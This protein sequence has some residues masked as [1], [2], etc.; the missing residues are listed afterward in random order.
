[1]PHSVALRSYNH[2]MIKK[3]L[4]FFVF[5]AKKPDLI[6]KSDC[7]KELTN[8]V[9]DLQWH[10]VTSLENRWPHN[11]VHERWVQMLKQSIRSMMGQSGFP[12]VAWHLVVSVHSLGC[13]EKSTHASA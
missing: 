6:V 7:T 5:Y 3:N 1:M 9:E 13:H 10:A 12:M 8:A 2:N 11:A 4:S